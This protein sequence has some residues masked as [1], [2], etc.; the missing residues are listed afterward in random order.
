MLNLAPFRPSLYLMDY[1]VAAVDEAVKLLL[2]VSQHPGLGLSEIARRSGTGKARAFRLLT[3]LEQRDLV[4]RRGEPATYL[5]GFQA[6]HLGAAAQ[7]QIDLVQLSQEPLERLHTKLNETVAVRVRD[8]LETVC[9]ARRES[10]HSLRVHGELGHRRPLYAG[11]SSRLLLAH[12]PET[13]LKAVL[14]AERTRFTEQTPVSKTAVQQALKL[15]RT[16][17]HA[18]SEGERSVG[19]AALA[20]P[21]HDGSGEVVAALGLSAPASRMT[22]R[23]RRRYLAALHTEAAEIS[24]RL[25]HTA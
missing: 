22:A 8:G 13:V 19:T 20:V 3:T 14:D 6:L 1:T 10:T 24:R 25:G 12:A 4:R 18:H 11:A 16:Q 15:V 23:H 5:L 9:V 21:I 7:A 17:G 2:L